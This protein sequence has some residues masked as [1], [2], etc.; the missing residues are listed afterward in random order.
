MKRNMYYIL[1]MALVLMTVP[2]HLSAQESVE[3]ADTISLDQQDDDSIKVTQYP[4]GE[5]D[6]VDIC[7]NPKYAIV[8]KDGRQGIYDM[9]MH[10]NVTEIE[11]REV[12][13]TRVAEVGDSIRCNWFYAKKGIKLG[14]LGLLEED[15]SIMAIWM[16][17]PDEVYSLDECT[18]ISKKATK[19]AQKLLEG[20]MQQ[21]QAT[22]V[23]MVLLDAKTGHL[24][25]WIRTDSDQEKE[26]AGKLL[27]HS[28]TGS[29]T[30]P[31]HA[32][33]AL[34]NEGLTLDSLCDGISYRHGIKTI[35]NK[36]IHHAIKTGYVKKVA[37]RKWR[38]LTDTRNLSTCPFNI[39][40]GYNSLVNNGTL[41]VPKMKADSVIVEENMFSPSTLGHLREIMSVDRSES[42]HLSW[43]TD[44]HGWLGYATTE[45]IFGEGDNERLQ[46]IGK[47]IA[48]AGV[49][50]AENPRYTIC[51][52]ADKLSLDAT[53]ADFKDIVNP[54]A[55]WLLK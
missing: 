2:S 50:P 1:G 6:W 12:G 16:D 10:Q 43:L 32:V 8:G 55:K 21:H 25:T 14:I 18:T 51:I 38:Q 41:I 23:Q 17:D 47:Q 40:I 28:C 26:E 53:P 33:L 39:A 31:F 7:E 4:L 27:A 52:V 9:E 15:N 35:N 49:F 54:L 37:E 3:V 29:L 36:V 20:F 11:Y 46:P 5:C 48:F 44:K 45:D 30:K 19:R 34:E 13:L 42:P 22:N 24:K